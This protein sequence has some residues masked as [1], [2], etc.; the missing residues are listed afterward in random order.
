MDL[1][2][3]FKYTIYKTT[4][5]VNGKVY[6]GCHKTLNPDDDYIGSGT[7]LKRAIKKHGRENF[8]KTILFVFDTPE[9]MFSKEAEIVDRLFVE[10]DNTYNLL[11]GGWGGF[12]Y[13]NSTGK[14][15]YGKNGDETHGSQNLLKGDIAKQ[16]L[17]EKGL[18][19]ECRRRISEGLH[20]RYKTHPFHWKGRKHKEESKRKI[21]EKAAINQRGSRNSQYGKCWVYSDAEKRNKCVPKENLSFYFDSEWK[22]GRKMNFYSRIV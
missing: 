3:N 6:I 10:S 9:E 1:N 12:D 19:E 17:I 2:L 15:I 8:E 7:I 5:R 13:L 14:N 21:G 4:N 18:W 11:E 16:F 22:R 20:Q